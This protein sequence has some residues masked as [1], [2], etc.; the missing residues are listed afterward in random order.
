MSKILNSIEVLVEH[1]SRILGVAS[2]V[3]IDGVID[4]KLTSMIDAG[5]Q[6]LMDDTVESIL[7]R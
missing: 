6:L 5:M 7:Y 1:V 2:R 4:G 3:D